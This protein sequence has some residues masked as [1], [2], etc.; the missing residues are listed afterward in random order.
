MLSLRQVFEPLRFEDA[1]KNHKVENICSHPNGHG[2]NA[3][4]DHETRHARP[5]SPS[6][7]VTTSHLTKLA[8]NASQVN[9]YLPQAGERDAVSLREF[10]VNGDR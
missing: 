5:L 10:L 8:K 6:S 3:T 4:H 1:E 7:D 2:S 9:G